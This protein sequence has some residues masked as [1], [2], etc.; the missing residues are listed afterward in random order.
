MGIVIGWAN[1]NGVVS[2]FS[3]AAINQIDHHVLSDPNHVA[4]ILSGRFLAFPE[5]NVSNNSTGELKHLPPDRE[6]AILD[7][8]RHCACL[9]DSLPVVRFR[10]H[11]SG[12]P[13]REPTETKWQ[14]RQYACRKDC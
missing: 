8:S 9:P 4:S 10:C 5:K 3:S 12:S 6:A 2:Y 11:A 7:R 1:L 14:T 13:T